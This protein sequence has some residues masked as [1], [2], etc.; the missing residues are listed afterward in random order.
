MPFHDH[1]PLAINGWWNFHVGF[2]TWFV[3]FS[4]YSFYVVKEANRTRIAPTQALGQAVRVAG[5]I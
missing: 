5:A 1:G 2:L 3:W 4:S